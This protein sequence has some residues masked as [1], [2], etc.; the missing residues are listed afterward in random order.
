[1]SYQLRIYMLLLI[2]M[3]ILNCVYT[4]QNQPFSIT[5]NCAQPPITLNNI[6]DSQPHTTIAPMQT[7]KQSNNQILQEEIVF[8]HFHNP[9]QHIYPQALNI[10]QYC[11]NKKYYALLSIVFISIASFFYYYHTMKHYIKDENNWLSWHDGSLEKLLES[12]NPVIEKLLKEIQI[13][14]YNWQ[15]PTD[16]INPLIQ[17]STIIHKEILKLKQYI[18]ILHWAKKAYL[19]YFFSIESDIQEAEKKLSFTIFLKKQFLEWISTHNIKTLN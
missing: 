14:Y 15:N 8:G 9:L 1:M 4:Q 10:L 6:M 19:N 3:F 16:P 17:F 7:T 5:I 13:R 12:N 2:H 18:F 11:W